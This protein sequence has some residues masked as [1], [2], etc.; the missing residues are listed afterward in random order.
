MRQAG[1]RAGEEGQELIARGVIA[2]ID[3]GQENGDVRFL[4][5]G[6]GAEPMR[7]IWAM[8]HGGTRRERGRFHHGDEA[9]GRI[10]P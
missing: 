8:E 10:V 1:D 4:G 3:A 5:H 6:F 7:S 9:A 2:G